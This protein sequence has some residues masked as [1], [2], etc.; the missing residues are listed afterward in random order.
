[1]ARK[2]QIV[3]LNDC[4]LA[5]SLLGHLNFVGHGAGST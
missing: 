3:Q 1:M 2:G 5:Q 4:P